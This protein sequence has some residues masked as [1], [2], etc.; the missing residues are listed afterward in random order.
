MYN[1]LSNIIDIVKKGQ[2]ETNMSSFQK[3]QNKKST[4]A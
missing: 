2:E 3:P 1:F 4:H